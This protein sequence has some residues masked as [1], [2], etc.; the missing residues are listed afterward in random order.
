M[1]CKVIL[2]EEKCNI[3]VNVRSCIL[4]LNCTTSICPL[5]RLATQNKPAACCAAK[6]G[7]MCLRHQA[8]HALDEIL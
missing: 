4:A 2:H 3:E 5:T 1:R 7:D 6:N 8:I